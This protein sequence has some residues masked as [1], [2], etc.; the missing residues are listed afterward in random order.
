MIPRGFN[1][2]PRLMDGDEDFFRC[3]LQVQ[4]PAGTLLPSDPPVPIR[5]ES[6]YKNLFFVA[7]PVPSTP[8]AQMVEQVSVG[9][10]KIRRLKFRKYSL[11]C[12]NVIKSRVR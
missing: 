10:G 4:L 1:L 9:N 8:T 12:E 5:T 11:C 7:A 6:N 2:G 3:R